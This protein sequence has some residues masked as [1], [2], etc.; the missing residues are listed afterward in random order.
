MKRVLG[1]DYGATER[2]R[3]HFFTVACSLNSSK[4]TDNIGSQF[5]YDN[6]FDWSLDYRAPSA[7]V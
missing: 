2:G 1:L 3:N 5:Y 6:L 4:M 7:I